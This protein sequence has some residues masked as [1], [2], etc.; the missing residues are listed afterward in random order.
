MF[1][2]IIVAVVIITSVIII[3]QSGSPVSLRDF[4]PWS[5]PAEIAGVGFFSKATRGSSSWWF[6]SFVFCGL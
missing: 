3:S 1:I 2:I 6:G 5:L 4:H